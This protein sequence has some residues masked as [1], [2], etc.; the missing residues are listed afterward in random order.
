MDIGTV[1]SVITTNMDSAATAMTP[2]TASQSDLSDENE[3]EGN[4]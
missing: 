1:F 4:D 3:N 2:M